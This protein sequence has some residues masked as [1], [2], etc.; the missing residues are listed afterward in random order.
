M[1]EGRLC[2]ELCHNFSRFDRGME[3]VTHVTY[4]D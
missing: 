3:K 2:T 4:P 1:F